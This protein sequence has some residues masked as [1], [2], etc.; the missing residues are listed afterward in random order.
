MSSSCRPRRPAF[1]GVTGRDGRHRRDVSLTS[2]PPLP[3][4]FVIVPFGGAGSGARGL[5][6]PLR[7][8]DRV[9]G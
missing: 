9:G 5:S 3:L 1:R 8:A 6:R 2:G 7:E 4:L